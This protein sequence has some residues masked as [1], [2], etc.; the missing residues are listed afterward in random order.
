MS[1]L[2]D[3]PKQFWALQ[4]L[5]GRTNRDGGSEGRHAAAALGTRPAGRVGLC[6]QRRRGAAAGAGAALTRPPGLREPL[7]RSNRDFFFKVFNLTQIF[8]RKS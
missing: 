5:R 1:A 3:A 2:L 7:G 4:D 8:M 6:S